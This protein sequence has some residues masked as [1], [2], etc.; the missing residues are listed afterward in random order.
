MKSF[1]E[2]IKHVLSVYGD[3][4]LAIYLKGSHLHGIAIE[5][6]DVDLLVVLQSTPAEYVIT[7]GYSVDIKYSEELEYKVMC[8][9]SFAKLFIKGH[10][11]ESLLQ[12]P[13]YVHRDFE[14][15]ADRL[16]V[17]AE[18]VYLIKSS[19]V[20]E[21]FAKMIKGEFIM[22]KRRPETRVKKQVFIYR[23]L[24]FAKALDLFLESPSPSSRSA[25]REA[26]TPVGERR[27]LCRLH[28]QGKTKVI[29][30]YIESHEEEILET[31]FALAEKHKEDPT[32]E[33]F[34]YDITSSVVQ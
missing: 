22:M 5:G 2:E 6:S 21:S 9:Y 10:V 26:L 4:V 13:I 31:L 8:K 7:E 20:F 32:Q 15:A 29:E 1:E 19:R 25:C 3:K 27:E 34:L 28:K 14:Q 16:H 17:Q 12:K 30:E 23:T 11:A 18:D 24:E 33:E